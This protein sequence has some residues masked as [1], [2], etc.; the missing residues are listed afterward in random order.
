MS[1]QGQINSTIFGQSNHPR[2]G[3]ESVHSLPMMLLY[4]KQ[5]LYV[6]ITLEPLHRLYKKAS[7]IVTSY[8][9]SKYR[10]ATTSGNTD[11]Y[12]A[13]GCYW[14]AK[15]GKITVYPDFM[16]V[17]WSIS[18]IMFQTWWCLPVSGH[19]IHS[20]STTVCHHWRYL[21]DSVMCSK[22][23]FDKESPKHLGYH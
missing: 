13:K 6:E 5:N 20:Q 15:Y 21:K 8:I 17:L 2:E 9:L 12:T 11:K 18:S 16:I 4:S 7:L 22:N 1:R 10:G 14:I 19:Q 23:T 3:V